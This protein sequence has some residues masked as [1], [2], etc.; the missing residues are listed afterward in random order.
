MNQPTPL[1]PCDRFD[2]DLKPYL[3]GELP[4]AR[5]LQVRVH[6]ARCPQCQEELKLMQTIE[7]EVKNEELAPL[8]TSL[9]AKILQNAPV[10]SAPWEMADE[11]KE[12]IRKWTFAR[13][14]EYGMV[15][16]L[17]C[18]V[19]IGV[20]SMMGGRVKHTFNSAANAIT[21][22]GDY[23]PK[24]R[25]KFKIGSA[26]TPPTSNYRSGNF[27]KNNGTELPDFAD[28]SVPVRSVHKEGSLMVAVD[29]AEAKGTIIENMAKSMGGFIASNTLS[30]GDGGIKNATI[31][32]RVP[33]DKFEAALKGIGALGTVRSKNVSGEDITSKVVA[34]EAAQKS[35]SHELSMAQARLKQLLAKRKADAAEIYQA[36]ILVRTLAVEA[37]RF[38]AQADAQ[39]RLV[40]LSKVYV[41]LQEREKPVPTPTPSSFG[42]TLS[43]TGNDAWGSFLATA[44]LPLQLLI[45]ILAYSPLWLPA[46]ILWRRF[47]RKMLMDQ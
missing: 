15:I 7:N 37:S 41:T 18:V 2:D 29:D 23:I 28:T 33:V 21:T 27:I 44:R 39:K 43:Q 4:F 20:L 38:K 1:T 31:D 36:R 24:Y 9:R 10:E 12:P 17:V 35:L 45:W 19:S 13:A 16:G 46:L 3:D 47:G 14:A 30:T 40:A 32:V 11:V 6:L 25:A 42:G 5:S 22:D 26:T 8:E 34:S